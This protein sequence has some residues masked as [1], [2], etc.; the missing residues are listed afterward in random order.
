MYP[1]NHY[2]M[3]PIKILRNL[4]NFPLVRTIYNGIVWICIQR[5]HTHLHSKAVS[6]NLIKGL[7]FRIHIEK[8]EEKIHRR[9]KKKELHKNHKNRCVTSLFACCLRLQ[10]QQQRRRR[11]FLHYP[12]IFHSFSL[13]LSPWRQ[14]SNYSWEHSGSSTHAAAVEWK[15]KNETMFIANKAKSTSNVLNS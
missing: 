7:L 6:C 12:A 3:C 4:L 15:T 1:F 8:G 5:A 14:L 13:P 11:P 9:P 2:P 10:R